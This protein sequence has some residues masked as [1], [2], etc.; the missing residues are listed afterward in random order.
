MS[1][2]MCVYFIQNKREAYEL[3]DGLDYIPSIRTTFQ[4][5]GAGYYADMDN[6]C[7]LFHVCIQHTFPTGRTVSIA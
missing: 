3:P 1:T 2:I 6:N 5:P 4:C 7:Q